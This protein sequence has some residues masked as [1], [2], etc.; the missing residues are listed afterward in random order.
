MQA[1]VPHPPEVLQRLEVP[2]RPEVPA[3]P[4]ALPVAWAA[5]WAA[6]EGLLANHQQ[7]R[8]AR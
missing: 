3:A 1:V 5:A 6:D 8:R 2:G 4:Q 7:R